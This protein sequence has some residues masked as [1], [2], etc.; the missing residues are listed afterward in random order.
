M[1]VIM[2]SSSPIFGVKINN[3]WN[4]QLVLDDD[5]P[6]LKNNGEKGNQPA[7]NGGLLDFQGFV[8]LL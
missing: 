6:S 4:H 1:L 5:K 8:F 2:G 3:L 7:K